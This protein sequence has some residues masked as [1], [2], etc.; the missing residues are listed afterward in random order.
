MTRQ[1]RQ[2]DTARGIPRR[3]RADIHQA[4]RDDSVFAQTRLADAEHE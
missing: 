3:R 1:P 2:L 4:A